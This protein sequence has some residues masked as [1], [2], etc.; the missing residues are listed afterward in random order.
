[1][2]FDVIDET[3]QEGPIDAP[4]AVVVDARGVFRVWLAVGNMDT[5]TGAAADQVANL[6]R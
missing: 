3:G 4:H 6:V 5:G 1:M 2:G